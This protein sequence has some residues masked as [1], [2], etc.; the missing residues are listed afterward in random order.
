MEGRRTPVASYL[1]SIR[2]IRKY[3]NKFTACSISRGMKIIYFILYNPAVSKHS[4]K[5]AR[6]TYAGACQR[7]SAGLHTRAQALE[8]RSD[9]ARIGVV[10][11]NSRDQI[12]LVVDRPQ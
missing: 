12:E 8:V 7:P 5:R 9:N 1:S 2:Q 11:G 10:D 4:M 3:Q 6:F